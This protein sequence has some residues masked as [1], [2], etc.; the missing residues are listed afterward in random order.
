MPTTEENSQ[1]ERNK[2]LIRSFIEEVLNEHNLLSIEKY[3]SKDFIEGSPPQAGKGGDGLKQFLTEFFE[4]FPDMHTTVEHIVTE[5][6]LVTVFLNGSGTHKGVFKG[7][8]PT[9]QQVNIRSADLYRIENGVITGHW[10]VIDQLNL[11]KQT[12]SLLSEST[13]KEFKDARVVWIRDYA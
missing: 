11:L 5:N 8:P 12:G 1:K 3:F 10:E 7:V 9:N 6:N 2:A 13:G 4:A